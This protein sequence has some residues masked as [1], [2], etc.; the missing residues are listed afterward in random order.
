M[1][2]KMSGMSLIS[3]KQQRVVVERASPTQEHQTF[4]K[5]HSPQSLQVFNMCY[6]RNMLGRGRPQIEQEQSSRVLVLTPVVCFNSLCYKLVSSRAPIRLRL[7]K[8]LTD[9][10]S[11]RTWH[12]PKWTNNARTS[13]V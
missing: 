9:V 6:L 11:L 12:R 4:G 5:Y 13:F 2:L 3:S 8:S 7:E 10:S 1:F